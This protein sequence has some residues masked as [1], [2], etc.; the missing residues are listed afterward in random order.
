MP[1]LGPTFGD[2]LRAQ[3]L[4]EGLIWDPETGHIDGVES[5]TATDQNKLKT[6]VAAHDPTRPAVPN[7]LSEALDV[8]I[9]AMVDE[10]ALTAARA[11]RIRNRLRRGSP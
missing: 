5:L 9:Q 10:G 1:R 4:G 7:H 3:G 8:L 6:V 11:T 2:E